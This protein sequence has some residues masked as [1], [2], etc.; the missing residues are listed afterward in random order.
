MHIIKYPGAETC[1]RLA[2]VRN[3]NML[4]AFLADMLI[5]ANEPCGSTKG[6]ELLYELDDHQ[7]L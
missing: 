7:L 5:Y 2:L 1:R 6:W 4:N 3:F